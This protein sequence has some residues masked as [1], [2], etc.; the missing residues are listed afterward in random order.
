ML[1][2]FCEQLSNKVNNEKRVLKIYQFEKEKLYL[3]HRLLYILEE[4]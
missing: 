1:L 2:K 4:E 3:N